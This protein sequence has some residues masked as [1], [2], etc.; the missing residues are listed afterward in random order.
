MG[1]DRIPCKLLKLPSHIVAPPLTKIFKSCLNQGIFLSE[2]KI[3][4]VTPIFKKCAKS[5]L[6]NYRPISV[7]TLVSNI[8]EKIIYQ[9]LYDYLN[10]NKLLSNYQSGFRSLHSTSTA[11]L[12]ATNNWSIKIDNGLLNGVTFIQLK[13]AFDTI[14]LRKLAN[15]GVD[16]SSLRFFASYQSNRCLSSVSELTC[17]VPQGSILGP[18]L[19]L[20]FIND[21]PN[22][23][24]TACAKMFAD[25]TNISI[26]GCTL[27]DL[28][29][30]I[31]SELVNLYC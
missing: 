24:T 9:Q 5:D 13:K 4:K 29:Q 11:L 15:Y 16:Q 31:N 25:D 20:I 12:E 2:R 19:F 27:A 7:L 22:C 18:L 6:S 1:L 30:R 26:S 28:E 21:L 10:G 3:A 17:G 23:L 14:D 8:F